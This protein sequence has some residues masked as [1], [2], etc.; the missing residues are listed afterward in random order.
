MSG[1]DDILA[2]IGRHIGK[3]PGWERLVRIF[4]SPERRRGADE[5]WVSRD[6][7]LFAADPGVLIGWN[8]LMFGSYEPELRRV[9]ESVLRPGDVAIDVGANVGWHTLLMARCVG[10]GGS[11]LAIEPNPSVRMRLERN[12]EINRL[13]NVR[14][15]PFAVS[16]AECTAEFFAPAARDTGAG[17]GHLVPAG[18]GNGNI[19]SVDVRTLDG[20]VSER[21]LRGVDLIKLDIEGF[22][23]PAMRGA[24]RTIER[25]RPVVVFE[26]NDEYVGRGTGSA[27]EIGD[28]LGQLGYRLYTVGRRTRPV[29]ADWPRSANMLA[30][31]QTRARSA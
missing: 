1:V 4:T 6:D 3:P 10:P 2:M 24:E 27:R 20:V 14:I 25:F 17:D 29:Q 21:Q 19:I 30:M 23:W 5:V 28:F 18:C 22:E 7:M 9:F 15:L 16:N 8:V 11:V 31:P 13:E 26:Y 12:V